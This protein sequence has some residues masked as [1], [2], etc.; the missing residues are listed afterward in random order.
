MLS[1]ALR[2]RAKVLLYVWIITIVMTW[3]YPA[4]SY[5]NFR[6]FIYKDK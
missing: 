2:V 5:D 4:T 6:F 3:R 1:M